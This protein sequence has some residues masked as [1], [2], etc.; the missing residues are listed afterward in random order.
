M[1]TKILLIEEFHTF[2]NSH[3]KNKIHQIHTLFGEF[4]VVLLKHENAVVIKNSCPHLGVKLSSSG[5][6]NAFGDIVCKEHGHCYSAKNGSCTEFKKEN[7]TIY[8]S[9][10]ENDSLFAVI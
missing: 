3:P 1:A 7:L 2:Y 5:V 4:G 8:S 6:V 9:E 10:I